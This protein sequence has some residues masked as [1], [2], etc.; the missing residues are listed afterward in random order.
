MDTLVFWAVLTAAAMHAGWNAVVKV[1]ND[2][3]SSILLL[4][5]IQSVLALLLLPF[6]PLPAN[7]AWAWL[8]ASALLHTGYKFVLSRAYEHGDLSQVYPLARGVA[9]LIA[10]VVGI[11][12]LGETMSPPKALSVVAIAFGVMAMKGDAMLG[13]ISVKALAYA[14][15]TAAFTASYT[16]VDGVGARMSGTPSGYTMWMFVG[17]GLCMIAF[18]LSAR[19]GGAIHK[20]TPDWRSGMAA[21]AMSLGSY[22]IAI[23][24]FTL[25]P[26]ALV[27]ALRETGVLFAMLIAVVFLKERAGAWRWLAASSICFGVILMRL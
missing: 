17:D 24:A 11:A 8:A 20:L 15:A 6:F 12:A 18:T 4:S 13:T 7:A 23:W 25:A 5:L 22:W 21:G 27:A 1:G 3:F 9:P 10:A 16:L 2:R 14:L 19:G 26:I